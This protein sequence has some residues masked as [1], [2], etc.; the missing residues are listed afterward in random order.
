MQLDALH[1]HVQVSPPILPTDRSTWLCL[2]SRAPQVPA[3]LPRSCNRQQSDACRTDRSLAVSSATS[4]TTLATLLASHSNRQSCCRHRESQETLSPTPSD[5]QAPDSLPILI[6]M[7]SKL[8]I[9]WVRWIIRAT[10]KRNTTDKNRRNKNKTNLQLKQLHHDHLH[11]IAKNKTTMTNELLFLFAF[12]CCKKL[13][14]S[15]VSKW[16]LKNTNFRNNL[17]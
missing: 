9:Y 3:S 6:Q 1:V 15:A 13:T 14:S 4:R 16:L 2:P 11:T 10:W 5:R 8:W 17:S 7:L 12:D